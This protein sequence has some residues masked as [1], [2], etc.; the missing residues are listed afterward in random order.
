[1]RRI[2]TAI[3]NPIKVDVTTQEAE[4]GK[5]ARA[6]IQINI[7]EEVDDKRLDG[8]FF[9]SDFVP[10]TENF[11]RILPDGKGLAAADYWFEI[12]V[13]FFSDGNE[14]DGERVSSK[15]TI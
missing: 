9:P 8:N 5:F 6:Y 13:G 14:S 10:P 15:I 1:M 2:A 11:R 7:G 3:A 4:R 12:F